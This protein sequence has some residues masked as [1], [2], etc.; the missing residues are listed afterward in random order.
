MPC[1]SNCS[2]HGKCVSGACV[3]DDGFSGADCGTVKLQP[4]PSRDPSAKTLTIHSPP[5]M[6]PLSIG[7]AT[8]TTRK[9]LSALVKPG[10]CTNLLIGF[11]A[12]TSRCAHCGLGFEEEYEVLMR[13]ALFSSPNPSVKFVRVD[14]STHPEAVPHPD[15]HLELPP[16]IPYMQY[17]RARQ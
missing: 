3:C 7:H 5:K 2:S 15:P 11:S 9:E 17:V 10:S 4:S 13:D 8:I 12:P 16:P 1:P 14:R 6:R